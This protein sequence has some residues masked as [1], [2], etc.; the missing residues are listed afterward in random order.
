MRR[1]VGVYAAGAQVFA[2]KAG[3]ALGKKNRKTGAQ[4][5]YFALILAKFCTVQA[6]K[7]QPSFYKSALPARA[8]R[9]VAAHN[10]CIYLGMQGGL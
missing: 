5:H 2:R 10:G 6:D 8:A 3:E 7:Q 9:T 4:I 1:V